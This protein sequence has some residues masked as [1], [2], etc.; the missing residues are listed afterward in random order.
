MSRQFDRQYRLSAGPSGGEG[1]E[2]GATST[3]SP[4]ALHIHFRVC[5]CDTETPNTAVISLWNLNPEQLAIL[6]EEDCLVTLRAGYASNMTLIFVGTVIF[7]S[8]EMDGADRETK[9]EAVDGRVELRDSYVSLSYCGAINTRK[10]IEDIA[11]DMGIPLTCSYNARF[12]DLLNGFSCI[13]PGRVALDKACASSDLRWQIQNG[14]MQVKVKDDTMNREVYV[15]SP[16]SGLIGIPKK[17]MFCKDAENSEDQSGFEVEYLLNGA[18]GIGDYVRLE[19]KVAQGY[20]RVRSVE[21]DG[22][23][24][25][26][27]WM[28]K[29]ILIDA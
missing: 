3:E 24:L 27:S 25:E 20:L 22:D 19:S 1:F 8:T 12:A 17:T 28:C 6:N 14:V 26:G 18:I 5:K 29:A 21:M 16:D 15:L 9:I 13:G 4:T 11:A 7:V 2:V 10:I 23:N